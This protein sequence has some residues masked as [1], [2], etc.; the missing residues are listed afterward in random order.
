M[1]YRG[2]KTRLFG[3]ALD[4]DLHLPDLTG[5]L[6]DDL[7]RVW[8]R[9]SSTTGSMM[10]TPCSYC[11]A[12]PSPTT[13]PRNARTR[14]S[15]PRSP[16]AA[17]PGSHPP[18][19]RRD[20][21]RPCPR[22]RGHPRTTLSTPTFV[23]LVELGEHNAV[24]PREDTGRLPV[25]GVTAVEGHCRKLVEECGGH[26]LLHH[27]ELELRLAVLTGACFQACCS[28]ASATPVRRSCGGRTPT[29]RHL[30]GPQ[31]PPDPRTGPDASADLGRNP[32]HQKRAHA[33]NGPS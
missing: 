31:R 7:A 16:L 32:G 20:R 4:V 11:C 17:L 22:Y 10:T 24:Q 19:P 13:T 21:L 18:H 27:P 33:S 23:G 8:V 25:T 3:A 30:G 29:D 26:G 5:V 28:R 2:S 6:A 14:S 12:P 9:T 15:P 1:R